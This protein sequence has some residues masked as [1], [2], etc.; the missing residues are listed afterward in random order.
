MK[1]TLVLQLLL[2]TSAQA[3]TIKQKLSAEVESRLTEEP[4][5][6]EIIL[7]QIES[8]AFAQTKQSDWSLPDNVSAEDQQLYEWH[9]RVRLDPTVFIEDLQATLDSFHDTEKKYWVDKGSSGYWMRSCEGKKAYAEAI[10][11]L[12]K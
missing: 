8:S 6:Q 7:G 5:I 1:T 10:E 12:K 3:L 4:A 11:F 9:N 2:A